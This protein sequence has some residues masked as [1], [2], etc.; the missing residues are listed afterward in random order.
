MSKAALPVNDAEW[1]DFVR[2]ELTPD[3]PDGFTVIDAEG[4]WFNP[5][6]R[7]IGREATKLVQIAAPDGETT[8]AGVA[9]V[10]QAYR[11][12]FH[13]DAVGMTSAPVCA[14]F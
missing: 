4:Q 7:H 2:T 6:T 5:G 10:V 11:Q 9:A 3:F 13:Q 14:T 8:A 1:A 12:R